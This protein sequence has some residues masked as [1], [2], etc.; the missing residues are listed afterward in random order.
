MCWEAKSSIWGATGAFPRVGFLEN[1]AHGSENVLQMVVNR[2]A[3]SALFFVCPPS[4]FE[5]YKSLKT[6]GILNLKI[7]KIYKI[8][9][10]F[11]ED[12]RDLRFPRS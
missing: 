10:V 1:E 7:F 2:G 9:K 12:L 6:C 5:M 4:I 11:V 3:K 8:L